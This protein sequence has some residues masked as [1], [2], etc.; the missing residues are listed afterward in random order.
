SL[1]PNPI[2]LI[3]NP[4]ERFYTPIRTTDI[5]WNFEK[6]LI[7]HTGQPRKRYTPAFKPL[8]MKAD[9]QNLVQE[10]LKGYQRKVKWWSFV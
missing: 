7:D 2:T 10:C 1:C 4:L 5:K 8:D 6:I 9:V 3:G